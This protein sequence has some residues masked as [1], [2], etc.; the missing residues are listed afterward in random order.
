MMFQHL[1]REIGSHLDPKLNPEVSMLV[2]S[3]NALLVTAAT[4]A[5]G[6]LAGPGAAYAAD[7][8]TSLSA[9]E[10][11]AALKAVGTASARAAAKGS[12]ISITLAG[13][14]APAGSETFV[15]DPVHRVMFERLAFAGPPIT[16]YV[17]AG[18]GTYAPVTD[19]SSR[20]ALKMMRRPSV[21]YVFTPDRST[22]L[23][24]DG[25]SPSALLTDDVDHAGTRT[26]HDDG[27]A[28]YRLTENDSTLT[29]HTD[30]AGLLTSADTTGDGMHVTLTY[31]YGP[32]HL[33]LPAPGTTIS[34]ATMEHGLAY[35]DMAAA[36]RQLAGD[37]ATGALRA[38]HGHNVSAS[39]LRKVAQQAAAMVN[40]A[41]G[42]KMLKTRN[43]A[44]G[45]RVYATNP[46][47]HH[48]V[49]YTVTPA[50]HKVTIAG[51]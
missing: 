35:L 28:D 39:S 43:T 9:S 8:P 7:T 4:M 26:L 31:A 18:R 33:T 48:T 21:R 32:Q 51:A 16:Q 19:P 45:V 27:S 50:G 42:I 14:G 11:S 46:W 6:L 15:T 29:V 10:M 12:K 44:G 13:G 30:T 47:T 37:T 34:A 23:D 38:A 22:T 36:V 20:A 5:A 41:V 2:V 24:S 40:R 25:M 49:S 1:P 3:R 17:A